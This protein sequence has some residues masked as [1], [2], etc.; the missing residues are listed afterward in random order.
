VCAES[1]FQAITSFGDAKPVLVLAHRV[2]SS[3]RL[4]QP[5]TLRLC[6]RS[7]AQSSQPSLVNFP[8]LQIA[9]PFA[10]PVFRD[11]G[12]HL[13]AGL[14]DKANCPSV[15]QKATPGSSSTIETEMLINIQIHLLNC[16]CRFIIPRNLG[17]HG[18]RFL[19][20][21]KSTIR[22]LPIRLRFFASLKRS[23]VDS[24]RRVREVYPEI[25]I[26]GQ[27]QRLKQ[28]PRASGSGCRFSCQ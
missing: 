13:A 10:W 15:V 16:G 20:G 4:A 8:P 23:S 28:G 11:R 14:R 27:S 17:E 24:A 25:T 5:E 22:L 26:I 6:R 18:R 12:K 7:P 1:A 19:P 3:H 21:S 2:E 9:A